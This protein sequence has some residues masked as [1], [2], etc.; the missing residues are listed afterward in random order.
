MKRISFFLFLLSTALFCYPQQPDAKTLDETA[1]TF[2]RQGDYTNA[3]VVYNRALQQEPQNIELLKGLAFTYYLQR[4]FEKAL[5]V[6]KPLPERSDAD[7]QS[8]QILGMV[9]KAI[10]EPK[11]CE[12]MY[13][14]GLKKFPKSGVLYNEFGE[15]LGTENGA[16]AIKLWE[17]GI[18]LDPN[19]SSNYYNASKY[20]YSKNE[21]VW[22]VLYG[23][24]F[25]NIESYSARTAEMKDILTEAYKKLFAD[26]DLL[27]NQNNKNGF[28]SAFIAQINNESSAI[29]Q[30]ISAESLTT[31]RTRFILSWFD[32]P[33]IE[34]PFRLFDYHR[35]LLKEGMFDAY[36]QWLFG[37]AQ[38]LEKFQAW[39]K[40]HAV[41]YNRFID[42][43]K[44]RIFKLPQGQYY[45]TLV[46]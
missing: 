37:A 28:V 18:E 1:K 26:A 14:L 29:S 27:K 9:Y 13:K 46:K 24:I 45:Q 44:G 42:F 15:V 35:Q 34:Y 25:V 10:E 3:I 17:K 32:K 39:S 5:K 41:E 33:V 4:D 20:Y 16:E 8:F 2:I 6:A 11:D 7:V 23:E 36:N 22:C 31:L 40:L 21:R 12:K 19:Y 30:G 38:N 43:Q